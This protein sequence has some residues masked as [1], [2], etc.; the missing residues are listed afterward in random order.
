MNLETLTTEYN[1]PCTC[2]HRPRQLAI[3]PRE[4]QKL[5]PQVNSYL[6]KLAEYHSDWSINWC[7]PESRQPVKMTRPDTN[8]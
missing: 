1:A 4:P 6:A 3:L 5:G 7:C 2:H 8:G